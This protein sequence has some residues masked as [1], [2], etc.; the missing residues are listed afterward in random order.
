METILSKLEA[1]IFRRIQSRLWKGIDRLK[2]NR[3]YASEAAK[4]FLS[5]ALNEDDR[6]VLGLPE[7]NAGC[8]LAV[9]RWIKFGLGD[10][11][12]ATIDAAVG[13][14]GASSKVLLRAQRNRIS[15][16]E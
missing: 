7:E 5:G 16:E 14:K 2:Y 1:A 6:K 11:H 15:E 8:E 12:L 10:N 3:Y 4:R 9:L 13:R